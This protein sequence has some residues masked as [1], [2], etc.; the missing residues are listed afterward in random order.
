MGENE[1]LDSNLIKYQEEKDLYD[2]IFS[3]TYYLTEEKYD[4]STKSQLTEEKVKSKKDQD[5]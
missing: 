5:L 3:E 2:L 1:E 4:Y